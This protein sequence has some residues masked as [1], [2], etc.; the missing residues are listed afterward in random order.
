M[1]LSQIPLR[2]LKK[3]Y[4]SLTDSIDNIQCFSSNDVLRR[5]LIAQELGRKGYEINESSVV[6]FTK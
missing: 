2:E 1:K 6:T 5:E 4:V 3:E